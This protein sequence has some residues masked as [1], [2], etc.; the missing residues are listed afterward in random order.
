MFDNL[1]NQRLSD[2]RKVKFLLIRL[3]IPCNQLLDMLIRQHGS[4]AGLQAN[5]DA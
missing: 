1:A 2:R 4:V 3:H 5:D